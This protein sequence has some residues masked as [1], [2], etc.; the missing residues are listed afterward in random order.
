MRQ[1]EILTAAIL[2]IASVGLMVKATDNAIGWVPG[3]GPGGGV[4][5]FWL[6]LGMLLSSLTILY[7]GVRGVTPESR[8]TEPFMDRHTLYNFT[9]AAGSL[10]VAI[11]LIHIIGVYFMM[12]LFFIFYIRF[13]GGQSWRVAAPVA[14]VSPVAIFALFEVVLQIIL[15][16]GYTGPLFYP[17]YAIVY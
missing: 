10:G 16:K 6:G 11:G 12:P 8:S 14:L 15:P 9:I 5:P 2:A 1:A 13:Y 7:R 3:V 4:F 17:I